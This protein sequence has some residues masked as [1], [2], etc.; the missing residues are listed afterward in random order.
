MTVDLFYSQTYLYDAIQLDTTNKAGMVYESL[1]VSP[2]SGVRIVEP[3]VWA[4]SDMIGRVHSAEYTRAI[5]TGEPQWLADNNGV[6]EWT[7]EFAASRLSSTGG[8]VCAAMRAWE[9]GGVSG[10]MSSGLH[11]AR[12]ECGAGYCTLNGLVIAAAEVVHHG[13]QRV[14]IVDLDAHGGGGTASMIQGIPALEQVDVAVHDFDRYESTPN[15]RYWFSEAG[16]YI[17]T[18][19]QALN[20]VQDPEGIDLVLY[21]AGVDPHQDCVMG[22]ARGITTETLWLRDTLV[23]SWARKNGLPICFVFAGGYTGP[24]LSQSE[25]VNLHRQ[26][27]EAAVQC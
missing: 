5:W 11:H 23:F 12:H 24:R 26:T 7:P 2:I 17:E 22:G 10:S 9:T 21:N 15:A 18:V 6:C 1:L 14:L 27:I 13:A 16:S 25:L 8:V 20:S 4:T 19:R 3:T